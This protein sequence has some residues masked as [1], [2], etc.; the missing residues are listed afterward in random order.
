MKHIITA[1]SRI[2]L[3]SLIPLMSLDA[4]QLSQPP[5]GG[6][7]LVEAADL[8]QF[9]HVDSPYGHSRMVKVDGPGFK[10]AIRITSEHRGKPWDAEAS[11]PLKRAFKQGEV[12]LMRLWVRKIESRDESRQVFAS[13]S[14]SM[15]RPPWSSPIS[16]NL[17]VSGDWEAFWIPGQCERD[18][19]PG[20]LFLKLSCGEIPQTL[21]IGGVELW[22]YGKETSL[23]SMPATVPRYDGMEAAA[24]WRDAAEKRIRELR[25]AP[26]SVEVIDATGKPVPDADVSLEMVRHAF[27]FGSATRAV[28]FAGPDPERNAANQNRFR[29]HFNS[30]TFEND[31]KWPAWIGEWEDLF[32]KHQTLDALKWFRQHNYPF[33]GHVLVWPSW[34][35]LPEFVRPENTGGLSP[36]EIEDLILGHIDDLTSATR[37]YIS[38]WDVLNEPRDN[39]DIMDLA[40][41][42]VMADWFKRARE[43]LP[44]ADLALN[45]FG[46][47]SSKTD[48]FTVDPYIETVEYLLENGAPL[49]ILGIQ[50]HMGGSFSPPERLLQI[51]DRLHATGLP[52]RITEYDLRTE[53]PELVERYT[54]DFL[55]VMFSH[56][57]VRGV[58]TWGMHV[59]VDESGNLTAA[60]RAWMELSRNEWWTRE[61]GTTSGDGAWR[62]RGFLGKHRI[63]VSKN[64]RQA[65]QVVYLEKTT[66]PVIV[67]LD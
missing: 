44:E 59:I 56:E 48:T 64:G 37:G 52:V 26:L 58:Q 23:A 22:S 30:A 43:R 14:V 17:S 5:E 28:D 34:H 33:R 36:G 16:R 31:T 2:L 1:L 53:F 41:R 10:E 8:P 9:D 15:K 29:E 39:H 12:L 27:Q 57:A 67:I 55:T 32:D 4:A 38:E 19:E 54:R 20:D 62:T 60:G 61:T 11:L 47:L 66:A 46:I 63:T 45:D 65:S 13:I 18:L 6:L 50:G 25:M 51:L 7:Q 49:T 24:E 42:P 21:E 3:A 35:N 40:G